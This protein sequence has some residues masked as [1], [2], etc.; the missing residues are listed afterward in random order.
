MNL[1]GYLVLLISLSLAFTVWNMGSSPFVYL[2]GRCAVCSCTACSLHN[3]RASMRF[4]SGNT[5]LDV[6]NCG[7]CAISV[8][9]Y[10]EA[11]NKYG[12]FF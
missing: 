1:E 7:T 8:G 5:Q 12:A 10:L 9:G 3:S 11:Q 4:V 2:T 6:M